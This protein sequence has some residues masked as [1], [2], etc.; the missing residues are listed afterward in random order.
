MATA[1]ARFQDFAYALL[2]LVSGLALSCHGAQ[3]LF[4]ILGGPRIPFPAQIWFGGII[5]LTCGLAMAFGW[6]TRIAAF[7]ASGTMAVAYIQFHWKLQ[8][9]A[10]FFP[11]VNK[12]EMA[13]IY[14]FLFFYFLAKGNGTW[15]V[16]R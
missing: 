16:Q 7:L 14:C 9:S 12:G 5:E 8:M 13:L 15:S 10:A 3:K 1:S 6:Y 2:R 11:L 4:G